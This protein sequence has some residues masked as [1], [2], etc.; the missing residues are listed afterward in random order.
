MRTLEFQTVEDVRDQ[1]VGEALDLR[2]VGQ[3]RATGDRVAE[4]ATGPVDDEAP[5]P[6][7]PGDQRCPVGPAA[8][9]AVQEQ[10][11]G[12]V[13][14]DLDPDVLAARKSHPLLGRCHTDRGPQV[15]LGST[16]ACG[17]SPHPTTVRHH[18]RAVM[19]AGGGSGRR[20]HGWDSVEQ[21]LAPV[22]ARTSGWLTSA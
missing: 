22:P 12:T 13:A 1:P 7:Q 16:E 18:G 11:R 14:R 6:G 17:V 3:L 20:P 5:E 19:R 9:T 4:T 10:D 21:R 8:R 15:G 2:Q